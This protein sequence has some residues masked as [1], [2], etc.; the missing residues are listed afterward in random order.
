M[1]YS[2]SHKILRKHIKNWRTFS[3]LVRKSSTKMLK[4]MDDLDNLIF[5]T[6]CQRSGTTALTNLLMRSDEVYN[7]IS[8]MDSE[9]F[10]ALILSGKCSNN[11]EGK[12]GCFQ[13]TYLNE[14]YYEYFD[15]IGK[16]KLIFITRNPFSVCYSM[17]YNWKDKLKIRNFALNELYLYCGSKEYSEG[18]KHFF[19][20]Y[21]T[22]RYPALKK[23][24]FSY[25][26]KTKQALTLK[27]RLG[28]YCLVID[29]DDMVS[30]RT[31]M[32]PLIFKFLN[33]RYEDNY[34]VNL[35][36]SKSRK[37]AD[38]LSEYEKNVINIICSP[39]YTQVKG[40]CSNITQL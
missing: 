4:I 23:A 21:N 25:V 3:K 19:D 31:T 39:I 34:Y 28:D 14:R 13:T 29:Y 36:N 32:L 11:I 2:N 5:V 15:H 33:L 30:C 10:G 9:L 20:K 35:L 22:I 24:V 17:M 26:S 7:Y 16:F 40:L 8:D 12:R 27:K 37:N 18:F 1:A 6:G 38:D